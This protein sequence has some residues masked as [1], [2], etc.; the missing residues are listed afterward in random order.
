MSEASQNILLVEDTRTVQ[1]YIRDIL[2]SL[3]MD[4]ELH[5]ARKVQEAVRVAAEHTIDLFIVD[6]G[7][8]DGDGIDFLCQM[9][10][11][12]P[13]ARALLITGTPREDYRSRA[14]DI[15][16]LTFLPKPLQRKDLLDAV[17][18][19]LTVE[20]EPDDHQ[21]RS[22]GG[23]E[24]TLGG[25]SPADIVQLKCLSQA[26]GMIE[27][28][29]EDRF[30]FVWFD[31]GEVRHAEAEHVD[32]KL[33]GLEAFEFIVSWRSGTVREV[34]SE[35]E[36]PQT[37]SKSWQSLLMDATESSGALAGC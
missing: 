34:I 29:T 33:S 16:V 20:D 24:G 2:R 14:K 25:L 18:Q 30:G 31:N 9:S 36:P 7:L 8:P 10:G 35:G 3:P 19:L 21:P 22:I 1:N 17:T 5:T 11:K 37:I 27:F 15:G 26:T 28:S 32:G 6:I 13:H 23:F 4:Y 12:H